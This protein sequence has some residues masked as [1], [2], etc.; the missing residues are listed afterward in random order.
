MGFMCISKRSKG[1]RM[2][3]KQQE[4]IESL[5]SFGITDVGKDVVFPWGARVVN[6]DGK[7]K[8]QAMSPQE[9][10]EIVNRKHGMSLTVED[11][12]TPGAP[13]RY[14]NNTCYSTGCSGDCVLAWDVDENG[15]GYYYC[16][17]SF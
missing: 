17:C 14:A 12:L 16:F 11:V 4:I 13:C 2:S 3:S 9:Y 10:I 15:F 6:I 1:S 8:L 5:K 7:S